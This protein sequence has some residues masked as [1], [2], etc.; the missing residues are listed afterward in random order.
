MTQGYGKKNT[1]MKYI[2]KAIEIILGYPCKVCTHKK[3][4]IHETVCKPESK[5]VSFARPSQGGIERLC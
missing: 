4:Q 5:H 3:I 2:N 1:L